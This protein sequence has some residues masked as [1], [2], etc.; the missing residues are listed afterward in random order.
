M[1][2]ASTADN[3]IIQVVEPFSSSFIGTEQTQTINANHMEMCRFPSRE[4][5][6][7]K[8]IVGELQIF[9]NNVQ[10]RSAR[11]GGEKGKAAEVPK[12]QA[13]SEATVS[14]TA[15]YA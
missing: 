15:P 10:E 13:P 5:A 12:T 7:Y 2:S 1:H 3:F 8:Q 4:D 11:K 6:G 9:M 14:S